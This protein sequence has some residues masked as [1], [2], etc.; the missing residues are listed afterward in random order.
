MRSLVRGFI[1]VLAYVLA[2]VLQ[3]D[4]Q[5]LLHHSHGDPEHVAHGLQSCRT[6]RYLLQG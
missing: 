2:K 3:L 5:S 1:H 4:Q 6:H